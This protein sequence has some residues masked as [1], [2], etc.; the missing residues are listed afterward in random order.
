LGERKDKPGDLLQGTLD[1]LILNTVV[2][3]AMHGYAIAE[4]IQQRS[5][6]VL[7]VEEGA[8]YPALHRLELRGWLESEWG[9]SDNN[10]RA[11]YY[12]IT[13]AGKKQL[14]AESEQWVRLSTAVSR[15]LGM[16]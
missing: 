12:R 15:V 5:D 11:K 14:A 8:L 7:R 1:L 4:A 10:R 9:V 16:A 6:E 3:G 2:R 13:A